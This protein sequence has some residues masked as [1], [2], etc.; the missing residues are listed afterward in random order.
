MSRNPEKEEAVWFLEYLLSHLNATP[1]NE[2]RDLVQKLLQF[3]QSKTTFLFLNQF[4]FFFFFLKS[5]ENSHQT[6]KYFNRLL[7]ACQLG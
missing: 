1:L 5:G 6:I 3:V 2:Q 7:F 4:F